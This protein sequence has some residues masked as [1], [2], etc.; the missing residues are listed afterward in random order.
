MFL[1]QQK[2]GIG[3]NEG[4]SPVGSAKTEEWNGTAWA[5]VGDLATGRRLGGGLG[6]SSAGLAFAG[7]NASNTK[8]VTTEEFTNPVLATKTVDVD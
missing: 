3:G 2:L 8:L 4:D 1:I 5:E 7:Q 6:T